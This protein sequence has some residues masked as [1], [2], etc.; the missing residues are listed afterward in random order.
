MHTEDGN[1]DDEHI[2]GY[3]GIAPTIVGILFAAGLILFMFMVAD[4]FA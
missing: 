2:S 3:Y 4:G 1:E